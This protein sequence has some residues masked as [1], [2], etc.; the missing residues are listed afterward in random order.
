MELAARVQDLSGNGARVLIE[1]RLPTGAC[2]KLV[3]EDNLYLGEV[4]YCREV[5]GGFQ[6]GLVLKHV[7]HALNDLHWLMQSL[8]AETVNSRRGFEFRPEPKSKVRH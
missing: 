2:V 8:L 3:L 7:L 1:R 6:A 4:A 5:E